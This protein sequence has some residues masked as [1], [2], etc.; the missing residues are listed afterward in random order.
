MTQDR[1]R[2]LDEDLA[3][4]RAERAFLDVARL[5]AERNEARRETEALRKELD[6]ERTRL[7]VLAGLSKA[8]PDALTE[9]PKLKGVNHQ[10]AFV[11]LCSDWHVGERVDAASVGGRNEYSPTIA[12]RRVD[13]LIDGARWMIEAWRQ[14]PAGY[15]W[16]LEE[17]VVWLG[18]DMITGMIH[19]DLQESNWLSPTQ[20]VVLAQ[21]LCLKVIES[22]AQHEGIK[23][24]VVPT[25][26]GNHGRDTPD[27]RVSTGWK[28]S[29]EWLLYQMIAKRYEGH[30]KIKVLSGIDEITRIKVLGKTIRF[31]HGDQ[32]NFKDGVGGITIPARKWLARLDATEPADVTCIGHWHQYWDMG[33]L[34]VNDSLIGETPYSQRLAPHH[35]PSQVCFLVDAK[36]GKRMS[37]PLLV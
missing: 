27:R 6:L 26:W 22:L 30:E 17:V 33:N 11:L 9:L 36:F 18:G 16:K 1:D 5:R 4:G 28:R 19:E 29:Y 32:F 14:G 35:P 20:E 3:S 23:R 34:I 13:K 12:T 21:E 25:S 2:L 31:N 15:G 10:G 37:T 8:Q 24:V 7:G